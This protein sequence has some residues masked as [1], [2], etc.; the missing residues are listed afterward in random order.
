MA[1]W[2]IEDSPFKK[3]ISIE[4]M[5]V[6]RIGRVL[7]SDDLYVFREDDNSQNVIAIWPRESNEDSCNMCAVKAIEDVK[8][9]RVELLPEGTKVKVTF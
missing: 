2:E 3:I 7:V 1:R 4:N 6:N 5:P 9:W 8:H